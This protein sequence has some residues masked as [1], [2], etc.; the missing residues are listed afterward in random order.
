MTNG[1][2][3]GTMYEV[4]EKESEQS[5]N[6]DKQL[7]IAREIFL[8]YDQDKMIEKLPIEYDEEFL[9]LPMLDQVYRISRKNGAAEVTKAADFRTPEEVWSSAKSYETVMT[10]YDV[11]GYSKKPLKLSGE[12]CHVGTFQVAGTPSPDTLYRSYAELFTNKTDTLNEACRGIGGIHREVPASADACYEFALFPFFPVV[13][14][15]WDGDEEF[16]AKIQVLWDRNALN[17][18]HYETLYYAMFHLLERL[19]THF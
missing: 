7:E 11:L 2:N 6:Y 18:L 13:F 1:K 8:R 9:Y 16:D 10:L 12:W 17:Y 3:N 4:P 15:F 19:K 5:S 14:E